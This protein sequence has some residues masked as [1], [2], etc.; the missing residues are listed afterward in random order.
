MG[1]TG[2]G[3][4]AIPQSQGDDAGHVKDLHAQDR[5]ERRG[6]AVRQRYLRPACDAKRTRSRSCAREVVT[7]STTDSGV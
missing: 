3:D 2:E 5:A 4:V 7:A 1:H 6:A